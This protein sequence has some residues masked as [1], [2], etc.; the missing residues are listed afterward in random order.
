MPQ[1]GQIH[2]A[3][4]IPGSRAIVPQIRKLMLKKAVKL[5]K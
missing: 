3:G 5:F 2:D 4:G 1:R